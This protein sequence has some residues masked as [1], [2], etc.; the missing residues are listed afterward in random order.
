MKCSSGHSSII[1]PDPAWLKDIDGR[2]QATNQANCDLH[3]LVF[4]DFY[5]KTDE[6]IWGAEKAHDHISSDRY[7][8]ENKLPVRFETK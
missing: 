6:D 2:Y 3:D 8:I 1:L 7:V 4:D 5:N